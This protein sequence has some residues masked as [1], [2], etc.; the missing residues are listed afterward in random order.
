MKLDSSKLLARRVQKV[1]FN[2]I[3]NLSA[4]YFCIFFLSGFGTR[5]WKT[6]AELSQNFWTCTSASEPMLVFIAHE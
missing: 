3:L 5:S 4:L 6:S 2:S 1:S